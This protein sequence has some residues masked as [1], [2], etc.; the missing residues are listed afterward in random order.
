MILV[1]FK[2]R[3]KL[4]L[5]VVPSVPERTVAFIS[6]SGISWHLR[7]NKWDSVS[8]LTVL[9]ALGQK[10]QCISEPL[11]Q[12]AQKALRNY[13]IVIS[14]YRVSAS[15]STLQKGQSAKLTLNDA[16]SHS[17]L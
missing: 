1:N 14:I 11:H 12:K 7:S 3:G 9:S 4:K 13:S 17:G 6:E 2:G 8:S 5:A 15:W 16:E 10:E